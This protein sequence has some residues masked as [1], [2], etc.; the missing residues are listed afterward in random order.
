[1]A[2]PEQPTI[3]IIG[4]GKVGATLA[5]LLAARGYVIR[6]VYS[7]SADHARALAEAVGASVAHRPEDVVAACDL[8]LLTV[9]DDALASVARE[10]APAVDANRAVAHTSGA[11]G[12]DVLALLAERGAL[13]GSLHPAFPFADV[14]TAM[15]KL[16]GAT[17]AVEAESDVLRVWL[18][19]IV[20]ALDG[21]VLI[22]P[23]GKKVLYHAAL[24]FASN[25]T[26][27]LYALA[28]SLL[29]GLGADR[30][31]AN[32]ALNEL[33][34]GTVENLRAQG[35]PDALTGPLV[36]ADAGTIAAHIHA[37]GQVDSRLVAVYTEL[38]RL[39]LPML[40]A[41]GVDT[42]ALEDLLQQGHPNAID[43]P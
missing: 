7:R 12:A 16:P 10:L 19:A 30:A 32:G 42:A 39:S 14:E 23:P 17:F 6:L 27:T 20:A 37:L 15:Q 9:P 33:V 36:R 22:V 40:V 41:R 25:Y 26:V 24:V 29:V 35:T 5:R 34:A 13:V 28:E 4:A 3:G 18:I 38:A 11:H 21:R 1:M 8:T 31:A 43:H 2:V